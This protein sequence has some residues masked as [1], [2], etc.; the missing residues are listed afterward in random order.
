MPCFLPAA[1]PK[2]LIA[3]AEF[4]RS[5]MARTKNAASNPNMKRLRK[6]YSVCGS[7]SS[8][9]PAEA[10]ILLPLQKGVGDFHRFA[11]TAGGSTGS[12]PSRLSTAGG[13]HHERE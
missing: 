11:P 12:I 5:L 13:D 8:F 4:L 9:W 10:S 3:V 7:V 6:Q 1:P 2:S